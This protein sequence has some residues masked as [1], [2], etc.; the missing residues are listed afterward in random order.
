MWAI[1][2]NLPLDNIRTMDGVVRDSYWERTAQMWLLST[3]SIIAIALAAFGVYGVVSYS[4]AQRTREFGIRMALGAER[5][6]VARLVVR[7]L[8]KLAGIGLASGIVVALAVMRFG[9]AL[10]FE[11][12][13]TDPMTYGVAVFGMAVV[14]A[15]GGYM[16]ARRAAK[17]DPA[18][19]LR[20]E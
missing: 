18:V 19:A 2:P 6:E 16:P 14:V 9:S 7:Q 17:L 10:L 3:L 20:D 13:Y 1:D 4:V 12:A 11:V 8:G 5:V 15:L